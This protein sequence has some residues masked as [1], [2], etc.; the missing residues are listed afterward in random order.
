MLIFVGVALTVLLTIKQLVGAGVAAT[1][2][3]PTKLVE[4]TLLAPTDKL[5]GLAEGVE[6][7]ADGVKVYSNPLLGYSVKLVLT[8]F[9][10][11]VPETVLPNQGK[12]VLDPFCKRLLILACRKSFVSP[13]IP[14]CVL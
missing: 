1:K 3:F 14:A 2:L 9:E 4:V 8:V 6:Q 7:V 12:F 5:A 10:L 13:R 11:A